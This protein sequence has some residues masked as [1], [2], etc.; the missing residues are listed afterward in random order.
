MLSDIY[1]P[2]DSVIAA[3]EGDPVPD[4]PLIRTVFPSWDND[5]RRPGRGSI[6]HGS[7]PVKFARW[8]DWA[9]TQAEENPVF[10]ESFV[11]INAW[12]EWAEGAYLEP[13]VHFGAAY[14]N[15]VSRVVRR[16]GL[17]T[18]APPLRVLLV[19][20]DAFAYGAQMLLALMRGDTPAEH[21][22]DLGFELRLRHS[23]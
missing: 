5:A 23:S 13:D 6:I 18:A 14:L 10:G 12:N 20:H 7:T 3:A 1:F 17:T 15:A 16:G 19:G 21:A 4:Y 11:C 22:V 2:Y 9:V 8:L